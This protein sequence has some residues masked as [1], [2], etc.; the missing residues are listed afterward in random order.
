M[1]CSA[2]QLACLAVC[3][4]CQLRLHAL[5][6]RHAAEEN[7]NHDGG[8]SKLVTSNAGEDLELAVRVGNATGEEAKPR[9]CDG[10]ED[11]WEYEVSIYVNVEKK[12]RQVSST[13]SHRRG[14]CGQY[15]SGHDH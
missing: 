7:T 2:D 15:A 3:P 9:S 8:E 6:G 13:Y 14:P 12:G 4:G 5:H 11:A 1:A 10:S